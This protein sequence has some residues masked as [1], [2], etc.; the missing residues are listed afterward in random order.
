MS[1]RKLSNQSPISKKLSSSGVGN[2]K[3]SIDGQLSSIH[4]YNQNKISKITTPHTN[5][6]DQ[7]SAGVN[8]Q[9]HND[10]KGKATPSK[11]ADD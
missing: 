8:N 2:F 5:L 6:Q 9:N 11:G 7:V 3:Q 1:R 4:D 10:S